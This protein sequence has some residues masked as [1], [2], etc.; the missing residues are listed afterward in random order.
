MQQ[1]ES[2]E[3]GP[4]PDQAQPG[5]SPPDRTRN[6]NVDDIEVPRSEPNLDLTAAEQNSSAEDS[7][8]QSG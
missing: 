7:P 2:D 5:A 6:L 4:S 8:A 1:R 3:R